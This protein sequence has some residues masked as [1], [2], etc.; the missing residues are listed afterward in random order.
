MAVGLPAR[1]PLQGLSLCR[2]PETRPL[3]P[4]V[5]WG[6]MGLEAADHLLRMGGVGAPSMPEAG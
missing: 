2:R 3:A 6:I 5:P 1:S 4:A